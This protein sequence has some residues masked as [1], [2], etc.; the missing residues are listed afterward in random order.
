MYLLSPKPRCQCIDPADADAEPAEGTD[1]LAT[2]AQDEVA[3]GIAA[4]R[5]AY[6]NEPDMVAANGVGILDGMP[7]G[8]SIRMERGIA[9]AFGCRIPKIGVVAGLDTGTATHNPFMDASD[10]QLAVA[11]VHHSTKECVVW[12][13]TSGF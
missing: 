7:E 9:L 13:E 6:V 12:H 5:Q 8:D 10:E 3:I 11:I 2:E 1:L 4:E